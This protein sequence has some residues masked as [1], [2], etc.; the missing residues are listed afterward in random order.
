MPR[1]LEIFFLYQQSGRFPDS[2][3]ITQN[4]LPKA[5]ATVYQTVLLPQ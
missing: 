1:D 3:I 4:R 2:Q 5:L